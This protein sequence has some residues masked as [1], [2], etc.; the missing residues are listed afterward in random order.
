MTRRRFVALLGGAATHTILFRPWVSRAHA[1]SRV[2]RVGI[3]FPAG[4]TPG[5]LR[6]SAALRELGYVE[7]RN[8]AYDVRAAGADIGRLPDLSRELVAGK[9]DVIVSATATAARALMN[10]TREIPIVLALVGDPVELGLTG[11]IARPTGNVTGF[12]TANDTL[13]GKRLEVLSELVPSARKVA[14]LWVP[15]NEQNRLVEQR[16]REAAA[17]LR[18][19]LLSLP[20]GSAE[21]ISLAITT[22]EAERAGALLIAPDP[23][24]VRNRQT[25]IDECLLRNLPAMHSYS[26]EVRDGALIAYGSDVGEDYGR[27]AAYVD[28][29]LKGNKIAD[30]PFQEPTTIGLTINLRTA[31]S[32]G[33]PIPN[34]LLVRATEVIE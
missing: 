20:V 15:G 1:Q 26:L 27:A 7:G 12:T 17:A 29:I 23:L 32:I 4:E 18:V 30:L 3:L 31:R 9:P 8:V 19:E 24:I 16:T 6:L 28:R 13:A 21:D 34:S 14:F 33:L 2:H 11:S 25:I 22:A 5:F 10:A